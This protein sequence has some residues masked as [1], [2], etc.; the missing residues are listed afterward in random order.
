MVA[1]TA[2]WKENEDIF[3]FQ[4]CTFHWRRRASRGKKEWRNDNL[5]LAIKMALLSA[6]QK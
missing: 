2:A 3:G 1:K 5:L 4:L 6:T